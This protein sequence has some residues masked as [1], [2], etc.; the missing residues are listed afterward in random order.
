MNGQEALLW[1]LT[2]WKMGV[3]GHTSF[4]MAHVLREIK[5]PPLASWRDPLPTVD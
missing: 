4:H 5:K 2:G 3:Q 1:V